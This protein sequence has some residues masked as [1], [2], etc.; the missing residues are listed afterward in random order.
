MIKVAKKMSKKSKR[1]LT[2]LAPLSL[3]MIFFF[4]FTKIKYTVN[5]INLKA[6]EL[7]SIKAHI[8]KEIIGLGKYKPNGYKSKIELLNN[9][10]KILFSALAAIAVYFICTMLIGNMVEDKFMFVIP[11]GLCAV[12]YIGMLFVSGI[13]K[14]LIKR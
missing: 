9:L 2:I 6:Q 14:K 5:I 10:L 4:I 13:L 8:R 1:R 7:D 11:L 3:F 12:V